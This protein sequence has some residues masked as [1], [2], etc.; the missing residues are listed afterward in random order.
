MWCVLLSLGNVWCQL[1]VFLTGREQRLTNFFFLYSFEDRDKK[2]LIPNMAY[3]GKTKFTAMNINA[4][5]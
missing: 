3:A 5:M 4:H 1:T 2:C